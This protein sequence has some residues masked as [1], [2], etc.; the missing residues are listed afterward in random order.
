[1]KTFL[2]VLGCL[3]LISPIFA[4]DFPKSD[5]FNA[6]YDDVNDVTTISDKVTW[7]DSIPG[8]GDAISRHGLFLT[9]QIKFQGKKYNPDDSGTTASLMFIEM[10]YDDNDTS[11]LYED[12]DPVALLVDGNRTKLGNAYYSQS[13]GGDAIIGK[14]ELEILTV[15]V[16]LSLLDTI[17][18]AKVIKGAITAKNPATAGSF[19][20]GNDQFRLL[21]MAL[22]YLDAFK[23]KTTAK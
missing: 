15:P 10:H 1:M 22:D 13:V 8:T 14:R 11:F 5:R 3:C 4:N 16:D 17:A 23:D 12:Q 9:L 19:L 18:Q 21:G 20:F 2:L 6:I 7:G